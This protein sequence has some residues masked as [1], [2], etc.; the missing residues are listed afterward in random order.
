MWFWRSRGSRV[1][2]LWLVSAVLLMSLGLSAKPEKKTEKSAKTEENHLGATTD[3]RVTLEGIT[4][5]NDFLE[6][7][8]ALAKTDGV[9]KVMVDAEAPGLITLTV[10][11]AGEARGLIESLTTFFPKKYRFTEKNL[12]T[13]SEINV[14]K[15]GS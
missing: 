15:A 11:Y 8:A 9:D 6:I 4:T 3:L 7:R 13:G 2:G 1:F 10:R 5:Y 14:S 12:K